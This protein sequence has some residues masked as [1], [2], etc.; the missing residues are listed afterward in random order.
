MHPLLLVD[1][2]T[3]ELR[4][5]SITPP[6]YGHS[7]LTCPSGAEAVHRVAT[8]RPDLVLLDLELPD[9]DGTTVIRTLRDNSDV[10]IIV[11]S[12]R[13]DPTTQTDALNR[14]AHDYITTPF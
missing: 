5:L 14:G 12:G 10:L 8:N 2:D 1:N 9:M 11:L 6:A 3:H 7:V 13:H 4:A